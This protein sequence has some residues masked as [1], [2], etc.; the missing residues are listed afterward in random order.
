M[1]YWF[2]IFFAAIVWIGCFLPSNAQNKK[3]ESHTPDVFKTQTPNRSFDII[4]ANPSHTSIHLTVVC[5]KRTNGYFEYRDIK[6]TRFKK[7][8]NQNWYAQ[9]MKEIKLD[10][11]VPGNQYV[12][13]FIYQTDSTSGWMQSSDFTFN[14]AALHQ[15][16]F[17]FAVQADSHLDNNTDTAVYAQSLRNIEHSGSAFMVDLGDTWMTDKYRPDYSLSVDQYAA[18]RY[19]FGI[20]GKRMPVFFTLGNHDGETGKRKEQAMCEWAYNTRSKH[21]INPTI[22]NTNHNQ[23]ASFQ[24]YYSWIWGD[25]LFIVLDPFRYTTDPKDPWNRTLGEDQYQ[26]LKK[27]LEASKARFKAVFIHNLV[28]GQ[29]KKGMARGGAEASL[30]YEW[31]GLNTDST[32]GFP[33]H[34]PGW[35]APIHALLKKHGVSIVFHGH[36]HFY[37][38]QER[39]GIIYQLVPQPGLYRDGNNQIASEYGYSEGVFYQ[40]PGYLFVTVDNEKIDVQFKQTKTGNLTVNEFVKHQYTLPID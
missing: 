24:N 32:D 1:K 18:Q 30:F 36:D 12:Y 28:G 11:L 4:L 7:T 5:Y 16:S 25:G 37:A 26:W 38:K 10:Q 21:F 8:N 27:T 19:Y 33:T 9:E 29:D 13:R 20:P 34:R 23:T 2:Y 14:T 31:G 40:A 39:D 22:P 35:E 6:Q 15:T 3:N 17:Q